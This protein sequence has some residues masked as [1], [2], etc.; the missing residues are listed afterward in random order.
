MAASKGECKSYKKR[1]LAHAYL[2]RVGTVEVTVLYGTIYKRYTINEKNLFTV[3]PFL[4]L[5]DCKDLLLK[6]STAIT[7]DYRCV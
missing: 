3:K 2:H 6:L 4:L 5:R 1:S 7:T